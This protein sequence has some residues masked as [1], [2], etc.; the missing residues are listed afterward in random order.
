[1]PAHAEGGASGALGVTSR[2]FGL[3]R[4]VAAVNASASTHFTISRRWLHRPL[5]LRGVVARPVWVAT[6]RTRGAGPWLARRRDHELV[7]LAAH[8]VQLHVDPLLGKLDS[9]EH[10][11]AVQRALEVGCR[12]RAH[13][14]PGRGARVAAVLDEMRALLPVLPRRPLG[15]KLA[16]LRRG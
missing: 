4:L 12:R 15:T 11:V 5:A 6:I 10:D 2:S 16:S 14:G 9:V 1:M 8:V 13:V 7:V 3:Q